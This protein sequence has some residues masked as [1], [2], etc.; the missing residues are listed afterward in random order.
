MLTPRHSTSDDVAEGEALAA[1]IAK[2]RAD[3]HSVTHDDMRAWLMKVA[4]GDLDAPPP[5]ARPL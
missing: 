4:A 3:S 2:A 1:A 5:V